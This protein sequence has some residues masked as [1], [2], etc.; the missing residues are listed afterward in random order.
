MKKSPC[1]PPPARG[2]GRPGGARVNVS[3]L[4]DLAFAEGQANYAA[5]R[6]L[7]AALDALGA[8]N[9]AEFTDF[10]E[11]IPLKRADSSLALFL[12]GVG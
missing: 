7:L 2:P 6:S 12:F 5:T 9:I 4:L 11:K 10:F 8:D 3:Q 1:W